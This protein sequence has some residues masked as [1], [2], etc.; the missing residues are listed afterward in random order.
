MNKLP[1]PYFQNHQ[2]PKLTK[3]LQKNTQHLQHYI[4]HQ[5]PDIPQPL[6]TPLPFLLFIFIFH[7]TLS[8]L[9]LLPL[10]LPFIFLP[11]IIPPHTQKFLQHYHPPS[12]TIRNHLLQYLPPIPLLKLFPQTLFSFKL[13]NQPIQNYTHFTI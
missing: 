8:L 3:L 4:P 1:L 13:F 12:T 11:F 6:T 9:S 10:I 7:S 2:T 5:L